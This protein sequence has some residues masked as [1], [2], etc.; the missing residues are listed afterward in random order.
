MSYWDT[1]SD[2]ITYAENNY[3]EIDIHVSKKK[4]ELRGYEIILIGDIVDKCCSRITSN[5][6]DILENYEITY[7][8]LYRVYKDVIHKK[9]KDLIQDLLLYLREKEKQYG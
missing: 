2:M 9:Q 6:I 3:P 5:P 4:F 7:E 8:Y 1:I